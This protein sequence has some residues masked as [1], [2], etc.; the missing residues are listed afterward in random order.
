MRDRKLNHMHKAPKPSRRLALWLGV[1]A[2]AAIAIF[3]PHYAFLAAAWFVFLPLGLTY[4]L[5]TEGVS[6]EL[7]SKSGLEGPYLIYLATF[8]YILLA[9][10][11]LHRIIAFTL[12]GA[13]I[14]LSLYGCSQ[15]SSG[16]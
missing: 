8:I 7:L 13:L 11:K 9:K 16:F 2:V 4:F 12:L 1:G 15:N 3:L 5:P 10:A 6:A 14:A